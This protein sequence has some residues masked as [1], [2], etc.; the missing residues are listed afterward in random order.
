[1]LVNNIDLLS[2]NEEI[3]FYNKIEFYQWLDLAAAE[4]SQ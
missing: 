3:D 2:S 1:M 4:K